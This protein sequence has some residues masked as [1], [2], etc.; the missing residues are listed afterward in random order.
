[1]L[2]NSKTNLIKKFLSGFLV[3]LMLISIMPRIAY[4]EVDLPASFDAPKHFG[5]TFNYSSFKFYIAA[6]DDMREYMEKRAAENP[7]YG[8]LGVYFQV[9][10]KINDGSWQYTSDWDS[11]STAPKAQHHNGELNGSFLH[12][13]YYASPA[14]GYFSHILPNN[15]A[16]AKKIED[17]GWDYFKSNKLTFRARFA[18]SFDGETYVLSPWSKEFV[19]SDNVKLDT[20]KMI[21]HA[22]VLKE[23]VVEMR[24]TTPYMAIKVE[25]TPVDIG[26]LNVATGGSVATEIWLRK[27]G[28]KE[29]KNIHSWWVSDEYVLFDVRTYF[30][31]Y[32]DNYEEAAFEIKTR[33]SLDLREYKQSG[34]YY[35]STSAVYIYS[36]FSN[37][38]SHNMP[39][40]SNAS[41]W[42]AGELKKAED[43]GLIPDMLKGADMT[44]PITRREFAAVSV[45][46]YEKLS[47]NTA[48]PVAKN[49]FTDT[50]DIEVLKAYNVGVTDGVSSDKFDPDKI[51]NRE[52]AATMLTRVFK[53]TFVENWSLKEDSKFT[54]N[55]TMPPKF[56]DDMKISDWAKPSVYFMAT[57]EIIKGV[58]SNNN[59]GPRAITSAE[60]ASNYASATR[61]Q[62]LIISMRMT[63]N[64]DETDA[65]EIVPATQSSNNQ[66]PKDTSIIGKWQTGSL[67]GHEYIAITGSFR[68]N[69][70]IGMLYVFNSE[71]SFSSLIVSGYGNSISI[72]GNY[73]IDGDKI[74]FTNKVGKGSSDYAKTWGESKKLEDEIVY[75]ALESSDKDKSLLIGLSDAKP[76]LDTE[77]NAVRYILMEE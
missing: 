35:S 5:A 45:K 12:G 7:D 17:M 41:S 33:Y 38:I 67:I 77:T 29:Y 54:F 64:L 26:E 6:P 21:N 37:V 25:K 8:G 56:A 75:F 49:P 71:G 51:L 63:E 13:K 66:K 24:G 58:D 3:L 22:P 1:M 74:V 42:A 39:A 23:A 60:Q 11:P 43:M 76:P 19:L 36:P 18:H 46:L 9:D 61:E 31:E 57:H 47:G 50:N 69:S 59:F 44:K 52:Q 73:K 32:Q 20:D 10:C 53:K 40:W 4:A 2:K 68:Y 27:I 65:K 14:Y 16:E 72:S 55:Y 62:S 15:E 34:Y 48:T 30:E 70:G 28:D